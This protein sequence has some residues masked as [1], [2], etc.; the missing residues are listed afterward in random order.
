MNNSPVGALL[1]MCAIVAVQWPGGDRTFH[2]DDFHSI[3]QNPHIRALESIPFFLVD[4]SRFSLDEKQAMYRPVVLT[5][6][7][8]NYALDG[9]AVRGYRA[10]NIAIHVLNAVLVLSLVR[11]LYPSPTVAWVASIFFAFH[12]LAVE[13]VHYVSCRSESLMALGALSAVWSYVRWSEIQSERMFLIFSVLAFTFSLLS[14]SVG[15]V[16]LALMPLCDWLLGRPILER[17]RGHLVHWIFFG[18]YLFMSKQIVGKALGSPVRSFDEQVWTQIKANLYYVWLAFI[19]VDLSAEHQFFVSQSPL[20]AVVLL[21]GLCVLSI[22]ILFLM[23][24]SRPSI[25]GLGWW[26]IALIPASA[27]PL[28]VLVNEH[29]IYLALVGGGIVFGVI[30]DNALKNMGRVALITLP[31]YTMILALLA[32]GRTEVWRDELSLWSDSVVKGPDMLKSHLRLGDA[33]AERSQWQHAEKAYLHAL[34]L[35]PYHPASRNNL[36]RLYMRQGRFSEAESQFRLVL[37]NAPNVVHARLNLASVLLRTGRWKEAET[38]Y[39]EALLLGD[40]LGEA[41]KK[42]GYIALQYRKDLQSAVRYYRE[43]LFHAPEA[44]TWTALGVALRALGQYDVAEDAY[45]SALTLNAANPEAWFNLANLYRD[46]ERVEQAR[47]AYRRVSDL[48]G[49]TLASKALEQLHLLT[50]Q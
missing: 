19:P 20:E 14:K 29:R 50:P 7:A 38:V 45:Q 39:K 40:T 3:V 42:L 1:L 10:M 22:G 4:P 24:A 23:Q 28:I 18:L 34:S 44:V 47:K 33:L 17:L 35:R 11:R 13:T 12:P 32:V 46:T 9:L 2:Y 43:G 27:V 41:Q 21:S 25:F 6:Y 5:S 8:V 49:E 36:G 37:A 48:A 30:F 16:V 31:F 26:T 15:C